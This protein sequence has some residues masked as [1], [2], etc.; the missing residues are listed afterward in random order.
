MESLVKMNSRQK[1]V[2]EEFD[3]YGDKYG[4]TVDDAIGIPGVNVDFFT[5]VKTAYLL[6]LLET[7]LGSPINL[8]LLDIGC[9]VGLYHEHFSGHVG[10][11]CGVDVSKACLENARASNPEVDY[12]CYDGSHLP[13]ESESFD[14]A[15]TIC[16]MHHVPPEA[17]ETFASEMGRILKPGGLAVVFEHNPR[18]PLTMRIV[19]RCP[20]DAD[21]I[22]LKSVMTE[23]LLLSAGMEQ[24]QSRTILNVPPINRFFQNVDRLFSRLPMGAQYYTTG[25]KPR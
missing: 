15:V 8:K 17:W 22:L 5:R 6:D 21:A 23:G 16:V 25:R 20:F 13:Y 18:N 3:Q 4:Q 7:H 14:A 2:A 1:N 9:G 12:K 19:N 11:V 24:V 10:T